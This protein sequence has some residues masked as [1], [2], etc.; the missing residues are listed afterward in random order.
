[1]IIFRRLEIVPP[2]S[3]LPRN[4]RVNVALHAPSTR[5]VGFTVH[6]RLPPSFV[7]IVAVLN[8]TSL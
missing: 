5:D 2:R 7:S 1:M 3:R 4:K 8:L 6:A